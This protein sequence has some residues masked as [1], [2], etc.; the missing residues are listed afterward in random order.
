MR[1]WIALLT[2]SL[3]FGAVHAATSL[4]ECAFEGGTDIPV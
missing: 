3:A 2:V 1:L 4:T